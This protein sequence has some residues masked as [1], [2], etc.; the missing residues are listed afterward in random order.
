MSGKRIIEGIYLLNYKFVF[1]GR[2][3]DMGL[4]R[5]DEYF[6][7]V[8]D[9]LCAIAETKYG[10]V[11]LLKLLIE[12]K[13]FKNKNIVSKVGYMIKA[14]ILEGS[15]AVLLFKKINFNTNLSGE[16]KC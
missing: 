16:I 13:F 4:Q 5:L 10:F 3:K 15:S 12:S 7:E 14:G 1:V 11:A 6:S 2:P 9:S 8:L